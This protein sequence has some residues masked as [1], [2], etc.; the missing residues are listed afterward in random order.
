VSPWFSQNATNNKILKLEGVSA[1]TL[2]AFYT[3]VYDDIVEVEGL[4]QAL[5]NWKADT[6]NV[7]EDDE[8]SR[9]E[10]SNSNAI[11]T[12]KVCHGT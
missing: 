10:D 8:H 3:W 2:Q 6:E 5:D 7:R 9:S 12:T 1:Q 11:S 4:Q